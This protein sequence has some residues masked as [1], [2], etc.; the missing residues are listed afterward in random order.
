MNYALQLVVQVLY[1]RDLVVYLLEAVVGAHLLKEIKFSLRRTDL[2][3][4]QLEVLHADILDILLLRHAVLSL[5]QIDPGLQVRNFLDLSHY[6]R[7]QQQR[8][9]INPFREGLCHHIQV[10]ILIILYLQLHFLHFLLQKVHGYFGV[11]DLLLVENERNIILIIFTF[12]LFWLLGWL[13]LL[14]RI[15]CQLILVIPL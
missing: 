2:N 9:L 3:L 12:R 8:L 4:Q 14:I 15:H 11:T 10:K 1:S 6:V 7:Q 5:H 13:L